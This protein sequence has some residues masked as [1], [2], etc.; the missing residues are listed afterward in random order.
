MEVGKT[1]VGPD[2]NTIAQENI[3][4]ILGGRTPEAY[5]GKPPDRLRYVSGTKKGKP[6]APRAIRY[7]LSGEN[8]P[9]LDLI[10]AIAHKEDLQPYQLLFHNLD[11]KNAPVMVSKEQQDM[12]QR[13]TSNFKELE[14]R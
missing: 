14:R 8:S 6:V 13:I 2:L 10:A 11:P 4:K 9:R 5:C 1:F 7:A 12:W 3:R